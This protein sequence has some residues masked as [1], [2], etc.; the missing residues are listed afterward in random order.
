MMDVGQQEKTIR[1]EIIHNKVGATSVEDII[2]MFGHV[3]RS[4]RSTCEVNG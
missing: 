2:K 3:R 4:L 1:R